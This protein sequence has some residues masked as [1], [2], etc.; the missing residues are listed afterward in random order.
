M[1]RLDCFLNTILFQHITRYPNGFSALRPDFVSQM[2]RRSKVLIQDGY[3]NTSFSEKAAHVP[4]KDSRTA[5]D[6]CHLA[7]YVEHIFGG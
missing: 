3:F 7:G 2:L 6:D 4:A 1:Y 5:G